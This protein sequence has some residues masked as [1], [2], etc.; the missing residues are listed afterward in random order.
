MEKIKIKIPLR[1]DKEVAEY[2]ESYGQPEEKRIELKRENVWLFRD[3]KAKG[4]SR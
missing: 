3:P 1:T 4:N 2:C